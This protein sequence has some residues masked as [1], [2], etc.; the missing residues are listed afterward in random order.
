MLY[1]CTKQCQ[2][3]HSTS[4]QQFRNHGFVL[5]C[6]YTSTMQYPC[7]LELLHQVKSA[8]TA[9]VPLIYAA[10]AILALNSS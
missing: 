1:L 3:V 9:L 7:L 2:L 5:S 8:C 6:V 4:H 10:A